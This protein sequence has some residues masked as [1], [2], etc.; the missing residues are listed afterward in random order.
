M[1]LLWSGDRVYN[2]LNMFR[3]LPLVGL[4]LATFAAVAIKERQPP[5]AAPVRDVVDE[6]HGMKVHDPYRYMENL[7][8]PEVA[9]WFKAQAAYTDVTLASIPGRQELLARIEQL[10]D[11]T[12]AHVRDV[13]RLPANHVFYLKETATDKVMKLYVRDGFAG[14]ER[15]LVDPARFQDQRRQPMVMDFWAPSPDAHFVGFGLSAGGSVEGAILRILDVN[16]GKLLADSIEDGAFGP[17]YWANFPIG[18]WAEDGK[19]FTYYRAQKLA[20]GA[21][22]AEDYVR[23]AY[24]HVLGTDPKHDPIIFGEGCPG[25][26]TKPG[27]MPLVVLT[28]K[29]HY[30]L[31]ILIHGVSR[32]RTIYK[33]PITALGTQQGWTKFLDV[34]NDVVDFAVHGDDL[35]AISQLNAS[36]RQVLA[37]KL[38]D[39]NF[40]DAKVLIPEGS[41]VVADARAASDA[42]YVRRAD[43]GA[44]RVTRIDYETNRMS[45]VPQPDATSIF[46]IQSDVRI[47]GLTMVISS[48]LRADTTYSYD[49]SSGTISDTHLE[50]EVAPLTGF[51]VTDVRV[52]SHDGVSVQLTIIAKDNVALDSAN[53]TLLNGYGAYAFSIDPAY[54]PSRHAW[55]ERGGVLAFAHIR[56]GGEYGE[57][58]HLAGK[59]L[60]KENT[61]KDFIA[62]AQYLID[63]KYTS[64]NRLAIEG[65]SAGG[66][67]I[68]RSITERPDL[69]AAAID[70]APM[71][72]MV[73]FETTANGIAN[74]QEFGTVK[75]QGGF[76]GLLKMSPYHHIKDGTPYPALLL[77][78]GFND[79]AV[80]PWQPGKMAAR[81]QAAT[82]SQRPVLLRVDY[83]VGH[84]GGT[85]EQ[86]ETGYADEYSFLLWQMGLPG[87]H[88]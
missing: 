17:V 55:L 69:F 80:A 15:L 58:W 68:G 77:V 36:N 61:W 64:P 85:K 67:T 32:T 79:P 9:A 43:T 18:S 14:G 75:T 87:F 81:L 71:S 45:R 57:A 25:V 38:S 16:S 12:P 6:Y 34:E 4:V 7:K 23:H 13:R 50:P 3:P 22:K 20:P 28:P 66:I 31:G 40:Q 44:G 47:P 48:W 49:P 1:I 2:L 65:G 73:R 56:G 88:P 51:R 27:D 37:A 21:S 74:V 26:D 8:D 35:Y 5:P 46:R 39:P 19:S 41:S 53:P 86:M 78:T 54:S 72:D 70:I 60:K 83:A 30:A 63:Y 62:C 10:Y 11:N 33:Q 59:G 82:S 76:E 42:L 84:G 29:S 52:K 24:L